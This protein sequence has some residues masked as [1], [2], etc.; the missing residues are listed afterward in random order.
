MIVWLILAAMTLA[1]GLGLALPL[2][3]ARAAVAPGAA[4]DLAVYRDQL[5][6]IDRDR[7]RGTLTDGEAQAARAEIGRRVLAAAQKLPADT[8][9]QPAAAP[10]RL[11]P[12]A[13]AIAA[14]LA[15]LAVYAFW[16]GSPGL[17]A[18]PFA[19]RQDAAPP[20]EQQIAQMVEGLA[21]KLRANPND[22]EGWAML[23]RSYATLDR[24]GA[25]VAAW[26]RVMDLSNNAA[27]YAAAF[28]ES[29]VR[30]ANGIVT[31][32]ARAQFERALAA[33]NQD[34]RAA[35]YIGIAQV[36][37]GDARAAMQTWTD[38]IARGPADAPWIA[39]VRE[40]IARTAAEAKIDPAT[41]RPSPDAQ[42]A[43]KGPTAADVEAIQRM[44]PDER[45]KLIRNMVDQLQARLDTQPD[46][47]DGWRRLGRA[48]MVL[49]EPDRAKA[50]FAKAM[51]LA[52]DR[53][54]VLVDYASTL[55]G[56]RIA[57]EAL[58]AEF[59]TIMRRV[60]DLDP[61]N[62]DALW[63]V[64]QAELEL[65][66]KDAAIALWDKLI[67]RIPP[68]SPAYAEIKTQLDKLRA[69]D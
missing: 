1:V 45:N 65:G 20:S 44:S 53:P 30:E 27:T 51:A 67:G 6:E 18:Q 2:L 43:R 32:E 11:V 12:L 25:A 50:A 66:H 41:I 47:V 62:G 3:R 36:Q 5:A 64:G 17:P 21:A 31:P 34:A 46:D 16:V 61:D 24:P 55:L 54:E 69:R 57:G 28:A 22:I 9:M 7:A 38:M 15:A 49:G 37:E 35:F 42:A 68:T 26:R 23:A 19:A 48:V 4:H 40:R 10:S 13:I 14:P 56:N 52:P 59:V 33:D 8:A 63:F 39:G 60:L 29:L 58:P